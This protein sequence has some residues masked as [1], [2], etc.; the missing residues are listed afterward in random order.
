MKIA[1][2]VVECLW[3]VTAKIGDGKYQFRVKA[4]SEETAKQKAMGQM[5]LR[6]NAD[7]KC[8]VLEV[9]KIEPEDFVE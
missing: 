1:R 3:V 9:D 2:N 7:K 5:S 4:E 8:E 6:F